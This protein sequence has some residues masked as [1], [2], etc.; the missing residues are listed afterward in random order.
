MSN[1]G[2]PQGDIIDRANDRA[3]A[4]NDDSIAQVR[5]RLAEQA[6]QPSATHCDDCGANIPEARRAALPGVSLCVDCAST[7]ER[8]ARMGVRS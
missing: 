1:Y 7:Q 6:A 8:R 3:Q 4:L 5:R 2:E